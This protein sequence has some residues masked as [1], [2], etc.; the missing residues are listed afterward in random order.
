MNDLGNL[1]KRAKQLVRDH[2]AGRITLAERLRSG[3]DR[4]SD[5]TDDEVLA[6]PFALHDA[7]LLIARELGF[8]NWAELM[9]SRDRPGPPRAAPMSS[10][11]AYSQVFVRDLEASLEW[12]R[13]VLNFDV[14]YAYGNPPFYGQVSRRGAVF[15][16]RRT[17]TTPWTTSPD[18]G[19]LLAVRI[20][21]EDVKALFLEARARGAKLHQT[22]RTEP[23]GQV[24]F[25]VADP[26]GNLISF[27]SPMPETN[28]IQEAADDIHD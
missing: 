19:D 11:Q 22:L 28:R 1:R 16:L 25:V 18:E 13:D 12:Y 4:F 14:D 17:V 15:N 5:M 2:G 6:A 7:Q 20:E 9:Q 8:E 10:W 27:G 26:D 23:W 3:L 21:V 24:T